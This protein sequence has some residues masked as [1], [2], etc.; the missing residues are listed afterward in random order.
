MTV[1]GGPEPGTANDL[2]TWNACEL[3]HDLDALMQTRVAAGQPRLKPYADKIYFTNMLITSAYSLRDGPLEPWMTV[4]NNIMS[5]IR[6]GVEWSFD[7]FITRSAFVDF[8]KGQKV[9]EVAV[10][11]FYYV[12]VLLANTHTCMQGSVHT[13]YFECSP[14]SVYEYF[15]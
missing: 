1:L 15:A 2:T 14:P 6:I 13:N 11:K 3:R 5:G 12:A 10:A 7:K 9:Q 4:S 8:V